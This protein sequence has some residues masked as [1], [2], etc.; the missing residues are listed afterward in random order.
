MT[1]IT[2]PINISPSTEVGSLGIMQLKRF[3]QTS[4]LQQQNKV[5]ASEYAHEY[6]LN[7]SLFATLGLGIEQTIQYLYMNTPSFAEFEQWVL[8]INGGELPAEAIQN[9]ND[10]LL[11]NKKAAGKTEK[12]LSDEDLQFWDEHGYVIVRNAIPKE[13][14]E[15]AVATI[16]E[17]INAD[18]NDPAT[19]YN[20]SPDKQGIMVQLFQHPTIEKNRRSAK[21]KTAFEQLWGRTDL[22]LST[23][24][25]G[26][27]P[28][29]T[30][31]WHFPGPDLHWDVSLKLPIPFATQGI[32][33]LTD[34]KENQGA[35]TLVPG[36]HKKIE[37]WLN[38]LPEGANPR[39][40]N[41]HALGPKPIAADQGDFIIWHQALPHGSSINTST[42]PRIVQYINYLP[43]DLKEQQ[44]WI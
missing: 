40:E 42:Q 2:E 37:Q 35:F 22:F 20:A 21:L 32:L 8:D 38:N 13:D 11:G 36:F 44:E 33:Y 30:E 43:M 17:Q 15:A 10:A 26:F 39:K 34:T 7:T 3:W 41:M 23:D 29:Q 25:C 28:P 4:L 14:C 12:V 16:L 1:M 6:N 18:L 19:W 5:N 27:N 9:F 24:R 31:E